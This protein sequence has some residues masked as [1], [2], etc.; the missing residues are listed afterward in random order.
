MRTVSLQIYCRV[1]ADIRYSYECDNSIG[2]IWR[3]LM[4][5]V[6]SFPPL[7]SLS[8]TSVTTLP[9]L[10]TTKEALCVVP[11]P[12]G[13]NGAARGCGAGRSIRGGA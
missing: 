6:Y 13:G 5:I 7:H 2:R 11:T 1:A 8:L 3:G 4:Y 12:N 10:V 9:S